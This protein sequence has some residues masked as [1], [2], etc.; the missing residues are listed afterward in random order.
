MEELTSG[1]IK[2]LVSLA[3]RSIGDVL[4]SAQLGKGDYE[5][6]ALAAD[7]LRRVLAQLRKQESTQDV[8]SV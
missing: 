6:L 1:E 4:R 8:D 3:L 7:D 2:D 5:S